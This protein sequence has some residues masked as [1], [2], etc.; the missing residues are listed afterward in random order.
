ML[1]GRPPWSNYSNVTRE[2]LDLISTEGSLPDIPKCP[3]ML[4]CVIN[5][6]LKRNPDMRPT[7]QQ[8]LG[9]EFFNSEIEFL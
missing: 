9:M 2:V 1:T 3:E 7:T 6:C 5:E 8:L 4:L